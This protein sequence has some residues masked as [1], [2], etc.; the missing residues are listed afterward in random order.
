MQLREPMQAGMHYVEEYNYDADVWVEKAPMDTQRFSFGAVYIDE[1]VYAFG[2]HTYC[3]SS[4][5]DCSDRYAVHTGASLL[6]RCSL[7]QH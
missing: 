2:G 6:R 5:A 3:N 7:V 4:T 1:G